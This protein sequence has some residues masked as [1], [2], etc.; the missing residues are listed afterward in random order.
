M[1]YCIQISSADLPCPG[2]SLVVNAP[3]SFPVFFLFF[4]GETRKSPPHVLPVISMPLLPPA[5]FSA[6]GRLFWQTSARVHPP[7]G[8][9][10]RSSCFFFWRKC[11][12]NHHSGLRNN[13]CNFCRYHKFRS[14]P[15]FPVP[16]LQSTET[17]P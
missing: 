11:G 1:V 13:G 16:L 15:S 14:A 5:F 4:C 6:V 3:V 7:A 10:S 12:G 2:H 17:G 9:F 8:L